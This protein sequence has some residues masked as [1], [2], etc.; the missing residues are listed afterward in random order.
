[1]LKHLFRTT[2]LLL[3]CIAPVLAKGFV[4]SC[5]LTGLSDDHL[6][7]DFVKN[8]GAKVEDI[9]PEIFRITFA[10]LHKVETVD[11]PLMNKIAQDWLNQH[12]NDFKGISLDL[13]EARFE[14][15][16]IYVTTTFISNKIYDLRDSLQ[17]QIHHTQ[18]PSGKTY[19][20]DTNPRGFH[21]FSIIAAEADGLKKHRIQRAAHT[22]NDRL[23]H[24]KVIYN[25]P[26]TQISLEEPIFQNL[27][28]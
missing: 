5:P 19:D 20:L 9:E 4:I 17:A 11:A 28:G 26:Y 24:A 1:M 27:K 6:Y 10:C 25:T 21:L 7:R 14:A 22:L 23:Q 12:K 15:D 3:T 2:A 18:F 8:C 13:S 16:K